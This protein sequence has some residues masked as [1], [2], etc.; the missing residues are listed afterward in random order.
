MGF[1]EN[2]PMQLAE[3]RVKFTDLRW[4]KQDMYHDCGCEYCDYDGLVDD[5]TEEDV[6]K[7]EARMKE[8]EGTF[9]TIKRYAEFHKIDIS[10]PVIS[11]LEKEVRR[12][13]RDKVSI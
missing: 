1:N 3:L 9:V 2:L 5:Y 13:P 11:K 7:I 4:F 8:I 6:E 10:D 12:R